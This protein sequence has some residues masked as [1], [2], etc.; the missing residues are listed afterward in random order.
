VALA[1]LWIIWMNA[2]RET[3][4]KAGGAEGARRFIAETLRHK[5]CCRTVL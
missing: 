4:G 2:A 3:S 5:D 1:I